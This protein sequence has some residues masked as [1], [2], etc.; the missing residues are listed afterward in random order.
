M[1]LSWGLTVTGHEEIKAKSNMTIQIHHSPGETSRASSAS[2]TGAPSF[3]SPWAM[4]SS[5]V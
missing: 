2:A 5:G 1:Y 4:A 3:R